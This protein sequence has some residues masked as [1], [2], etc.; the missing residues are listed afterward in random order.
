MA[1]GIYTRFYWMNN[2]AAGFDC[3]KK[4]VLICDTQPVAVEGM[5]WLIENSGDLQF[6]GSVLTLEAVY[7]LLNPGAAR[8]AAELAAAQASETEAAETEKSLM[9]ALEA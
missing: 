9:A 5:K 4:N 2:E 7:D 8:I 3:A 6:A 1:D